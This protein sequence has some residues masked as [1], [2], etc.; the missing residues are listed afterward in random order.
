MLACLD[1]EGVLV[2][3]I[4]ISVAERTGIA[5]LRRTLCAPFEAPFAA[6]VEKLLA[7]AAVPSARQASV[8]SALLRDRLAGQ[9]VASCWMLRLGPAP[10]VSETQLEEGVERLSGVLG[11]IGVLSRP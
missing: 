4:W 6:E 1:L 3:E 7:A 11:R 8:R 9:E 2:P 10:Y 5:A